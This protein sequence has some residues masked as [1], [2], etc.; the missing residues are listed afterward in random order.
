VVGDVGTGLGVISGFT[1]SNN[2]GTVYPA[3]SVANTSS[4]TSYSIYQNGVEV[5]NSS[6]TTNVLNDLVSLQSIVS[7]TTANTPIEIYWKVNS[8]NVKIGT[9]N[10]SLIRLGN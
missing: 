3:G 6:R 7:I 1:N 2:I 10:L 4:S 5:L 8:G 9:R